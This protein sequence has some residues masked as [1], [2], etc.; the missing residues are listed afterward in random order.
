[1][2]N[3][4]KKLQK[5]VEE[6]LKKSQKPNNGAIAIKFEN[7]STLINGVNS[8]SISPYFAMLHASIKGNEI[9]QYWT[10]SSSD[11]TTDIILAFNLKNS[12]KPV[13][14]TI[15]L[16]KGEKT[17]EK[18]NMDNEIDS[19][20]FIYLYWELANFSFSSY[21]FKDE[22]TKETIVECSFNVRYSSKIFQRRLLQA[23]LPNEHYTK[24]KEILTKVDSKI[25]TM[26]GSG[27]EEE[28][29]AEL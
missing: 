19:R 1:M 16:V 3:E 26:D 4:K 27:Y 22:F 2:A 8:N 7:S 5:K 11:L 18:Y 10:Q 14:Y 24:I 6:I 20:D 23:L 28:K 13:L 29:E 12:E 25:L 9:F 15:D 21:T 17:Y